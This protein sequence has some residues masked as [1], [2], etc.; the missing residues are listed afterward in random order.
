MI[1]RIKLISQKALRQC[2]LEDV[3]FAYNLHR[4][5]LE[6]VN[7]FINKEE[8]YNILN[9]YSFNNQTY[10]LPYLLFSEEKYETDTIVSFLYNNQQSFSVQVEDCYTIDKTEVASLIFG[11]TDLDHPGVK[12][13]FD[14]AEYV[15][16]GKILDFN[17]NCV[18]VPYCQNTEVHDVVFQSRNP[19]H[20]AHEFIVTSFAPNLT[21]STPFSTT[22]KTDYSFDK[23]IKTFEEIARRYGT[24]VY[25]TTL[26]RVFAGPREALQNCLIFQNKG[27]KKLVMGRG[28]NCVGDFYSETS[29]YE[30]CRSFYDNGKIKIE[31]V[32]QDT[33]YVD[34]VEIKGSTI[35]TQYIDKGLQP[36]EH[37]MSNYI[38]EILLNE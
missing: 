31:P 9:N 23:K 18:D 6:P 7:K 27:A 1:W 25:V 19:P 14:S 12:K 28:K 8:L 32:W 38:S 3:L 21:Y 26:P 16:A 11:T 17:E 2:N 37:F 36:P 20:K 35:K 15:I 30:L 24:D 22:K 5:N 33:I 10:S 34:H 29:S 13:L 4:G